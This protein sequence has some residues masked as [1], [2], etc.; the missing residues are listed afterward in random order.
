[1]KR[2]RPPHTRMTIPPELQLALAV[3]PA[4]DRDIWIRVG[5]ALKSAYGDDGFALW[6]QWSATSVKYDPKSVQETWRSFKKTGVGL[7]TIVYLAKQHGFTGKLRLGEETPQGSPCPPAPRSAA[8]VDPNP[9]ALALWHQARAVH[10]HPYFESK[11]LPV[12]KRT[13]MIDAEEVRHIA[14]QTPR[15]RNGQPAVGDILLFPLSDLVSDYCY[16]LEM[17]AP[18]GGKTSLRNQTLPPNAGWRSS[19]QM[20]R[21][22]SHIILAEGVATALAMST[23]LLR[24]GIAAPAVAACGISRLKGLALALIEHYP[25]TRILL[26]VDLDRQTLYPPPL[27][28][29]FPRHERLVLAIPPADVEGKDW[30]DVYAHDSD[31]CATLLTRYCRNHDYGLG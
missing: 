31:R 17:I 21:K 27:I 13:R 15:M 9:V 24:N 18:D 1:M 2:D 30:A 8:N 23:A 7:G 25:D 14:K 5:M 20:E 29:D 4:D 3:I 26:G 22:A 28:R 10:H 11:G 12:P 16:G 19:P 6:D